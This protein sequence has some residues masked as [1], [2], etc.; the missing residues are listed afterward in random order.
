MRRTHRPSH[1]GH[2]LS[3]LAQAAAMVAL[4]A[5]PLWLQAQAVPKGLPSGLQ[6]VQGQ[7]SVDTQGAQM[8]VKNSA[9]AILNWQTFSIG[10]TSGVHFEQAS[11]ASKVLNRVVGN[12]PSAIFGSLTSNGQVWLLN[13][14][15]VLFGASARV[16][17][18]GLVT[19]TLRL[20]DSDFLAGRYR[21]SAA[22]GEHAGIRNEGALTSSFGGHVVLLGDSVENTGRITAPGGSVSLAAARSVEL[23]D[24]GLPNL[25]VKV[26]VPAG[27][28]LN[29]GALAAPGG[30]V[31]VYGGIVNQSGFV[32]AD[33]LGTD[34]QGH[35]VLHAADRLT[36]SADSLTRAA[37]SEAGATGGAVDLL[38]A[39]VA[40]LGQAVVDVSGDAAGGS[41]RL[42]G[43]EK[44]QDRSVP[45]ARA[46]WFAP[47]AT[48]RADATG[49]VGDGGRI[50]LWS[51]EA[52][53]AYGTLS[54]RGGSAAGDGGFI[55]TSGGWLDARPAA[56]KLTAPG[57][58]AGLWLLDP[59]D[60][61]INDGGPDTNITGGPVFTT[62]NDSS[63]ISTGTI[64]AALNAGTSV[65][66]ATGTGGS[67]SQ[68][69]DVFFDDATLNV[70]PTAP[71]TFTVQAARDIV[72]YNSIITST[73]QP[74]SLDLQAA[75]SGVGAIEIL[76][77]TITTAGGN[78]TLGGTISQQ[79]PLPGGGLTATSYRPAV[80]YL[81][82]SLF[83]ST[84]SGGETAVAI[85]ASTLN[86]GAGTLRATGYTTVDNRDGVQIGG[87]TGATT[88]INAGTIEIVGYSSV[89]NPVNVDVGVIIRGD[90]TNLTA[91]QAFTIE[92]AGRIGVAI[93]DGARLA[94]NAA[95]ASGAGFTIRGAGDDFEGVGLY[96]DD[97]DLGIAGRGTRLTLS[98]AALVMTGNAITGPGILMSNDAGAPGPI[99]D[100]SAATAS[101]LS[102][103]ASG[104]TALEI[105]DVELVL[106]RNTTTTLQ[107]TGGVSLSAVAVTGEDA[108]LSMSGSGFSINASTLAASAG[109]LAL[110]FA[111]T[112]ASPQG[113]LLENTIVDTGG[114]DVVF[115]A[116]QIVSSSL[117]GSTTLAAPWVES[118]RD[119]Q[120]YSG[121]SIPAALWLL[122]STI[123]AGNGRVV[124]GGA[125]RTGAILT[126]AVTLDGSIINAREITLAG[127]TEAESGINV[128]GGT[129]S[130]T[131][132]IDLQSLTSADGLYSTYIGP[133]SVLRV[134]DPTASAGSGLNVQAVLQGAGPG[135][136]I[137]GGDAGSGTETTILVDGGA[138]TLS[139]TSSGGAGASGMQLAGTAAVPGGLLINTLGATRVDISAVNGG[140]D[141]PALTMS[142]MNLL[143]PQNSATSPLNISGSGGRLTGT[144]STVFTGL[145]LSSAGPVSVLTDGLQV[146]DSQLSGDAGLLLQTRTGTGSRAEA[147]IAITGSTLAVSA[148]GAELRIEGSQ[149]DAVRGLAGYESGQGVTL[150]DSSLLAGGAGARVALNGRGS[151]FGGTGLVL[152]RSTLT[153]TNV[154]LV[155]SGTADGDGVVAIGNT[156]APTVVNAGNLTVTGTSANTAVA[157]IYVG[158]HLDGDTLLN[159][160]GAGVGQIRGDTV[161]LGPNATGGPFLAE[162]SAASFTVSA[163]GSLLLNA[164]VLDFTAGSGTDVTL[165]AD[166]D[167]SGAGRLRLIDST[168]LTG[169]GSFTGAGQG[170]YGTDV[171]GNPLVFNNTV[172][173][174]VIGVLLSGSNLVDAGGGALSLTGTSAVDGRGTIGSADVSGIGVTG[175]AE[176][177]GGSITLQ[178]S[179][180]DAGAGIDTVGSVPGS[181]M[182]LVANSIQLTGA[183]VG[184]ESVSG[185]PLAGL[186]IGPGSVWTAAP[187]GT[188]DVTS[189]ASAMSLQGLTASA[190]GI[191]LDAGGPL[192]LDGSTFSSSGA[193]TAAANGPTI[194]GSLFSLLSTT[195]TAGG[196]LTLDATATTP[197]VALSLLSG[198]SLTGGSV[199]LSGTASGDPSNAPGISAVAPS[200]SITATT[201]T[202][203]ITGRNPALDAEGILLE[204]PWVLQAPNV[205][206]IVSDGTTLL[207]SPVG[208]AG[209]PTFSASQAVNL[210]LNSPFGI[211]LGDVA[212]ALD[213]NTLG[214]ALAGQP[215]TSTFT[216]TVPD[217]SGLLVD[218]PF[219]LPARLQVHSPLI[220]FSATGS[221]TSTA[222]GDAIVLDGTAGNAIAAFDNQ[223]GPGALSAPNGRWVVQL[224]D[225]ASANLGGLAGDFTAYNLAALPWAVDASGNLITPAAGNAI[226]YAVAPSTLTG[227]ALAG[228]LDKVYDATTGIT[229]DPLAWTVN[230]LLAGDT[231]T[232]SGAT[233]GT[234]AD[235][236]VGSGKAV[237]LNPA[238]IFTVFDASGN[239]VFGYDLPVFTATV[240]P[241]TL[242]LSGRR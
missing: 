80:G 169:G 81:A 91:T 222:P 15:G 33:T 21:F 163:T 143:G 79:L 185:L 203:D 225:P 189:V 92:G 191:T 83:S 113:V 37:G 12:D 124:G 152:T 120:N 3:P 131:R 228:L 60:I 55:E 205:I 174:G 7:A 234:L 1:R 211:N 98:N 73:G 180:G 193:F 184:T 20:N 67:N 140:T 168:V 71:V 68:P 142:Y 17:V 147:P 35:V 89:L 214:I 40:V 61:L 116:T 114:G 43:G 54:A 46:V 88:T 217:A 179:G 154:D 58:R 208:F 56:V 23:V 204:G 134:V 138:L 84:S 206:N 115:G 128:L 238:S 149:G 41:I 164:S 158:V 207:R 108:T 178:G 145:A 85:E 157:Q 62:T 102:S 28:V 186:L 53:R 176:L 141:G 106:A 159:F 51:N 199:S 34:A 45:N 109:T 57:G 99:L 8:T 111:T 39:Q 49:A 202:L 156:V 242:L 173:E 86:L 237:T 241:A 165:Q 218:R 13:P 11:T 47:E 198:V 96:A 97:I 95:P 10:A 105:R 94:L 50:V 172:R 22:D 192:T 182:N 117:L 66:V 144:P 63:V 233:T 107:G 133:G 32:Q 236:N 195:V 130:A 215:P 9:G 171:L 201:G 132:V 82:G 197:G 75:G 227:T 19:S 160:S 4:L 126:A 161:L 127:R 74:L 2:R 231:L 210:T 230:G 90:D 213:A 187:T 139:G 70:T 151:D 235:K 76:L 65:T 122:G 190:G 59:N 150:T 220:A 27:E 121:T 239:P 224:Q 42:G 16:D 155:G 18:A 36:L 212:S 175:A 112:G 240:T 48:L 104:F 170:V 29:L 137:E 38:G 216:L 77:S 188:L 166:S 110:N 6:V 64:A 221:L 209:S 136:G 146:A 72:V 200:G 167:S 69:G 232:L 25:K 194:N 119:N 101:T 183:G 52:T 93:E 78:V 44:G 148:A 162:G 229:L 129:Y 135:L 219:S 87:N 118:V 26:D 223:A 181:T 123:D 5:T 31:D 24:T 14:N 226:G 103:T 30:T 177:R 196:A 100:L 125:V 153:A